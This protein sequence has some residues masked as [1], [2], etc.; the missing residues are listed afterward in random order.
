MIKPDLK[1][2]TNSS[3]PVKGDMISLECEVLCANPKS[4]SYNWCIEVECEDRTSV[5]K[6][7]TSSESLTDVLSYEVECDYKQ[8][9]I[10]CSVSNGVYDGEVKETA[11]YSFVFIPNTS[12]ELQTTTTAQDGLKKAPLV[13]LIVGIVVLVTFLSSFLFL[14]AIRNKTKSRKL[15]QYVFFQRIPKGDITKNNF[16]K[17][18]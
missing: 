14:L 16:G 1:L 15:N 11:S 3:L 13:L 4:F 18:I 7:S 10:T 8:I 2:L 5:S 17:L 6:N 12:S 9:K